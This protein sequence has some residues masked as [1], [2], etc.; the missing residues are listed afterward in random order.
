MRKSINQRRRRQTKR[1]ADRIGSKSFFAPISQAR[2]LAEAA[3]C[4]ICSTVPHSLSLLFL[5]L[6]FSVSI[7]QIL[8]FALVSQNAHF[9]LLANLM[10]CSDFCRR[11][12]RKLSS[13]HCPSHSPFHCPCHCPSHCQ[14]HYSFH[15]PCCLRALVCR[16][17][18][19]VT[20]HLGGV[21][22][23]IL[24]SFMFVHLAGVNAPIVASIYGQMYLADTTDYYINFARSDRT[25]PRLPRCRL[26]CLA[27]RW[28][29]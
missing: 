8:D 25:G 13:S 7:W 19:S 6:S 26:C 10:R 22:R 2:S 27:A 16:R 28:L 29:I 1:F 24:C 21:W 15:C 18:L 11:F 5:S 4:T 23:L 3:F 14:F 20:L 12:L 9:A 17:R